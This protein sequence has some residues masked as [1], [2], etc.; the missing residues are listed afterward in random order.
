MQSF[1]SDR[2]E[3]D[4]RDWTADYADFGWNSA[5]KGGWARRGNGEMAG[6]VGVANWPS[7]EASRSLAS[8]NRISGPGDRFLRR[9]GLDSAKK[10]LVGLVLCQNSLNSLVL[11]NKIHRSGPETHTKPRGA[12]RIYMS[13]GIHRAG[14]RLS[15]L[16]CG[17][18]SDKALFFLVGL[19]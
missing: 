19:C 16:F 11:G 12:N 10:V 3:G 8:S 9:S 13:E 6:D 15:S 4:A 5:E 18:W 1:G 14:R 17:R 2:Q 7:A